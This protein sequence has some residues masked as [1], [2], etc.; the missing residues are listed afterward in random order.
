V[1]VAGVDGAWLCAGFACWT[2]PVLLSGV[3]R[4]QT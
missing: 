1:V 2:L 4:T 3:G